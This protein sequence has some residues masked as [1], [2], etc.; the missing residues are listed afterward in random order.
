MAQIDRVTVL[1]AACIQ[2]AAAL[3]AAKS[4]SGFSDDLA[5]QCVQIAT[6]LYAEVEGAS[7]GSG[8]KGKGK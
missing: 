7:W 4:S 3:V 2:A 6:R 5:P 1:K 8:K